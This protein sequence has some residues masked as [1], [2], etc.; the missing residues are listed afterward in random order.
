MDFPRL[1]SAPKCRSFE[2]QHAR[3]LL[4]TRK[5]TPP[6]VQRDITFLADVAPPAP[7]PHVSS[8]DFCSQLHQYRQPLDRNILWI[9]LSAA[10]SIDAR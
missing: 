7:L 2:D 8:K 10:V 9:V 1:R 5:N 3:T 4:G 6:N